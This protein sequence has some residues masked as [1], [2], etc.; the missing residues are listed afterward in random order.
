[1]FAAV[2]GTPGLVAAIPTQDS[3]A[4]TVANAAPAPMLAPTTAAG[5]I[6]DSTFVTNAVPHSE[7]HPVHGELWTQAIHEHHNVSGRAQ[8]ALQ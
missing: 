7:L 1:M 2:D 5:Q 4:A 3:S 6:P 8:E